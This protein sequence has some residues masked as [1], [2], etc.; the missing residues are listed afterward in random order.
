[1]NGQ[2]TL[3][4]VS[5]ATIVHRTMVFLLLMV[6]TYAYLTVLNPV[7]RL[8]M[9]SELSK[10]VMVALL[11]YVRMGGDVESKSQSEV[12]KQCLAWL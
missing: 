11:S 9:K 3:A 5:Q 6:G 7:P 10:L 4:E 2:G 12:S 1:M 8:N